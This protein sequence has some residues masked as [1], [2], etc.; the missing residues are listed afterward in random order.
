LGD[1]TSIE[2]RLALLLGA[3]A[4]VAV[5]G[6]LA[7]LPYRLYQRDI[8]NA[9]V[10]AHRISSITRAA[11]DRAMQRGEDTSELIER[12]QQLAFVEIRLMKLQ[13]G[14]AHPA[15]TSGTGSS[16]LHSTHLTYVSPPIIDDEGSTWLAEMHFDLAPMKRESVVLI[17]TLVAA[18][19]L[20]SALFSVAVFLLIRRSLV[21]PLRSVT[22]SIDRLDPDREVLEL[23]EHETREM[24]DL[25]RALEKLGRSRGRGFH[26]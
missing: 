6:V 26:E 24:A 4:V 25:S 7:I 14:E 11:L 3:I 12:I 23:P 9:T 17:I 2:R 21:I 1:T 20:G 16:R 18:V 10:H 22:E 8:R 15:L 5:L 19:I 13:P